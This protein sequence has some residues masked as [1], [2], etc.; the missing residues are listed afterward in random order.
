MIEPPEDWTDVDIHNSSG[1]CRRIQWT[2]EPTH[3][4]IRSIGSGEQAHVEIIQSC[5]SAR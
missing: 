1:F 2:G 4:I 5:L 3:T